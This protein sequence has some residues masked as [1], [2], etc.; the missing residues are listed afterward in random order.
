[1]VCFLPLHKCTNCFAESDHPPFNEVT[2][3]V[4]SYLIAASIVIF[5]HEGLGGSNTSLVLLENTK[6]LRLNLC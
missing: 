6:H 3:T 4:K 5:D 1:M 2:E